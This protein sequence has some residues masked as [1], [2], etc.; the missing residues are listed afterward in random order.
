MISKE[1]NSICKVLSLGNSAQ[2]YAA[3]SVKFV[4]NFAAEVYCP[5][6]EV[7]AQLPKYFKISTAEMWR[8]SER[9]TGARI[10]DKFNQIRGVFIFTNSTYK[11]EFK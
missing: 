6:R 3:W 4:N 5:T 8:S 7:I 10:C 11:E 2:E 9:E 1:F